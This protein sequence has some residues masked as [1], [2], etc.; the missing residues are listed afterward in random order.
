M[1]KRPDIRAAI[2]RERQQS[3]EFWN[4][5]PVSVLSELARIGFAQ[6]TDVVTW[7]DTGRMNVIASELIPASVRA[8][9]K[10]LEAREFTERDGSI[11]RTLKVEMHDKRPALELL[12]KYLKL[13]VERHEHGGIGGGPIQIENLSDE[14]LLKI[15]AAAPVAAVDT[16]A[17]NAAP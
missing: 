16:V 15:A 17:G 7:D 5:S 9:V 2:E 4:V 14:Q 8:A 12:G 3:I 6:I 1:M 11:T 13:F 10:K